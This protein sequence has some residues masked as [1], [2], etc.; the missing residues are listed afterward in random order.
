MNNLWRLRSYK[1]YI[2]VFNIKLSKFLK[3]N[4]YILAHWTHL[5]RKFWFGSQARGKFGFSKFQWGHIL[6]FQFLCTIFFTDREIRYFVSAIFLRILSS[7]F[8]AIE[9]PFLSRFRW[10][11]RF[12]FEA[13][14]SKFLNYRLIHFTVYHFFCD[15]TPH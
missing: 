10:E 7:V 13:C 12:Y 6:I 15:F 14:P 5:Y 2:V 8:W 9:V 1:K 11:I 4:L 3:T